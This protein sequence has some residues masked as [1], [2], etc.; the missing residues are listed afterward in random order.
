MIPVSQV[1]ID[2]RTDSRLEPSRVLA[3]SERERQR[4]EALEDNRRLVEEN[5]RLVEE[6]YALREAAA[7]WIRLYERQL[8]RANGASRSR[9]L[10]RSTELSRR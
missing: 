10:G 9:P 7:M 4:R 6:N 2:A 5:A 8:E 3:I 1:I